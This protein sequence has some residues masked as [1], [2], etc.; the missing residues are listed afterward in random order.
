MYFTL[1]V[2]KLWSC[3]SHFVMLVWPSWC[4]LSTILLAHQFHGWLCKDLQ[5]ALKW[6]ALPPSLHFYTYAGHC[7]VQ[8]LFLQFLHSSLHMVSHSQ[9][10]VFCLMVSNFLASIILFSAP[11][12]TLCASNLCAKVNTCSL[13]ASSTFFNVASSFNISSV[14]S[15]S[16]SPP[17]NYSGNS[18]L[19]CLY[20]HSAIFGHSLPIHSLADPLLFL[21]NFQYCN[22]III[23]VWCGLNLLLRAEIISLWFYIYLF[24]LVWIL[25]LE[26]IPPNL[27][28]S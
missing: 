4:I 20:F 22:E 28:S 2:S 26:T 24:L 15:F 6:I 13:M 5:A 14:M 27:A 23:Q 12:W 17:I 16:L 21:C 11:V 3:S 8:C 9:F 1:I 25:L 10:W 18:L 7:W 19:Y